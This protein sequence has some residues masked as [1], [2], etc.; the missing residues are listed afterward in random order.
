VPVLEAGNYAIPSYS[1]DLFLVRN[2]THLAAVRPDTSLAPQVAEIDES[3]RLQGAFGRWVASL[4]ALETA[5]RQATV[6]SYFG[7]V[8]VTPILGDDSLAHL[9]WRGTAEDVGVQGGFLAD[10]EELGLYQVEG[11]DLFFR[12]VELEPE[13]Q[14]TYNFTV[15]YGDPTTDPS[16][17]YSVDFGFFVSS[18]IRTPGWPAAPHLEEPAEEVARG[19]LDRFP[20]RSD[21]LDNTREIRV[22]RPA[23][24][25]HDPEKRYP[26]LVVNHGDNLL[27][28]GLMQN[29]LDN[30]VGTSVAPLVAVFVPRV[31]PPEYGG[32]SADDYNRFL[33][34][35]LIPHLDFHYLTDGERRAIMG[36]GS[37]GVSAVYAALTHPEIFQ[38]AAAQSFYPI[39]PAEER[40]PELLAKEGPRPELIYVVWS[41]RD[42]DLGDGRTAEEASQTL[43]DQLKKAGVEVKEQIANYTPGWGGWR[44]QDDEI[45]ATFFPLPAP[46]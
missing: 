2:L 39:E 34:E 13:A 35:E 21:I 43:R 24:Y 28:G 38:M 37:A 7:E 36:P 29:T 10:G 22:W 31:A 16:N 46:E 14:Y 25:G 23:D 6:E 9:V 27:R 44:G 8:A 12:T 33:I 4:E 5:Q 18:E 32:P 3:D 20:F 11:T 26:L 45:L 30:L 41:P 15:D 17:P 42:Y 19:T 1:G 40:I